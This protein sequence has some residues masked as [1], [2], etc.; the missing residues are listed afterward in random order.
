[1][2][3]ALAEAAL[4]REQDVARTLARVNQL[5]PGLLWEASR[6]I[7]EAAATAAIEPGAAGEAA[8]DRALTMMRGNRSSFLY[9]YFTPEGRL[10][11]MPRALAWRRHARATLELAR[12]EF[13]RRL[14]ARIVGDDAGARA[15]HDLA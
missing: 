15:E 11:V 2:N 1:M 7:D 10:R 14:I 6:S 5:A 3:I 4:G 8:L 12:R 13:E 9:T